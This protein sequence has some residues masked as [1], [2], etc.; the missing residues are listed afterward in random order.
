MTRFAF[1]TL[2]A[3]LLSTVAV[4][5]QTCPEI[6]DTG[7]EFGAPVGPFPEDIPS[8]CSAFEILVGEL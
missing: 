4:H 6:P 8:G 5:A 7:V 3:A 2:V 1:S